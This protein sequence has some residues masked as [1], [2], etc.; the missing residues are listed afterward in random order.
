[1]NIL[2]IDSSKCIKCGKCVAECPSKVLNITDQLEIAYPELC[3]SCGHCAAICDEN[4]IAS[5][6]ENNKHPFL[7]AEFPEGLEPGQLLFHKKRSVRA[8]TD[9]PVT[10]PQ[11]KKLIE[12]AEKAPSSHNMRDREYIVITDKDIIKELTKK[13]IGK[14]AK[15]LKLLNPVT[16][17][18]VKILSKKKYAGFVDHR[19]GFMKLVREFNAGR[20]PIFRNSGCIICISSPKHSVQIKDDCIA[21][22][23]YMLLY[24]KTLN[25]DSFIVGYAQFTHKILERY[26]RLDKKNTI[27]AVSVFGFGKYAYKKEVIYQDPPVSWN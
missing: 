7:I 22:Q 27:Y 13:I 5:H 14:Y 8:F 9:V 6:P 1:M 23:Q 4:A 18:L 11:I 17:F 10:E 15:L 24:A 25:I 20:D 3:I 12:Y 26:L 2:E 21:A 16:M 19:V